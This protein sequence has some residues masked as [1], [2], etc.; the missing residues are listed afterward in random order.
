MGWEHTTFIGIHLFSRGGARRKSFT[1]AG[2]D[3]DL[4]LLAIG[5]GGLNDL[6]AY[7]GGQTAAFV[8]INAPRRPNQGLMSQDEV[9]Q[10]LTPPPDPGS[11]MGYRVAEYQL[12]VAGIPALATSTEVEASPVWIRTGFDLYRRLEE[13]GYRLYPVEGAPRQYLEVAPQATFTVLLGQIPSVRE[14]LEG[15]MQRQLVLSDRKVKLPDPLDLFEEVTRFRILKGV[16][17]FKDI[18]TPAELD[19]LAAAY[20]AWVAATQA[21]QAILLGD[22]AEGQ[23]VLPGPLPELDQA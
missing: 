23:I 3:A 10:R 20:T 19:A 7:V 21:N 13:C 4:K 1:Y 5:H 12:R 11:W 8:G 18:H 15:R 2:L 16:L 9:R 22:P 6:L 14:S 17:P